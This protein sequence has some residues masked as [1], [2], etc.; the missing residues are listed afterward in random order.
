MAAKGAS[1]GTASGQ[2][3]SKSRIHPSDDVSS[4]QSTNDAFPAVMHIAEIRMLV[5]DLLPSLTRLREAAAR[6]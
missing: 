1:V 4:A 6:A 5:A 2:L 3:N